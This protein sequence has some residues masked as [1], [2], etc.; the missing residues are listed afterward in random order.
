[1]LALGGG[2]SDP[3]ITGGVL[4]SLTVIVCGG[5][6]FPALSLAEKVTVVWPSVAML[7]VTDAPVTVVLAI[8]WAP[9]ALY[10]IS[11]TPEPPALSVALSV[12]ARSLLFHPA[13]L[14][15]GD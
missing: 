12:T 6:A 14:G 1:P 11:L 4:S 5:S 13:G 8:G 2:V 7:I 9:V 15:C 10:V 3:T